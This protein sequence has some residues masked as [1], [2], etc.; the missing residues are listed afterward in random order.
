MCAG[1]E[2]PRRRRGGKRESEP[3]PESR[4]RPLSIGAPSPFARRTQAPH[5]TRARIQ[6]ARRQHLPPRP[7]RCE[8]EHQDADERERETH[9]QRR[10]FFLLSGGALPFESTRA[11]A[12]K[13]LFSPG[14]TKRLC[15]HS[16]PPRDPSSSPPSQ[17]GS[18]LARCSAMRWLSMASGGR[19]RRRRG[20]SLFPR[21]IPISRAHVPGG[22]RC[23]KP[24][25]HQGSARAWLGEPA[26][27]EA[28]GKRAPGPFP[29]PQEQRGRARGSRPPALE[30]EEEKTRRL[31]TIEIM[32]CAVTGPRF[33]VSLC[34]REREV[35]V[36]GPPGVWC[37]RHGFLLLR[38][39][40]GGGALSLSS[41]ARR[42]L[43]APRRRRRA[44][45]AVAVAL[46][47]NRALAPRK[48]L[49]LD[50]GVGARAS[51]ALSRAGDGREVGV[52]ARARGVRQSR[53]CRGGEEEGSERRNAATSRCAG[54]LVLTPRPSEASK[55]SKPR[56]PSTSGAHARA[57]ASSSSRTP[58]VRKR[59][60][61]SA[62]SSVD[63]TRVSLS[64]P[65][66]T[67][68]HPPSSPSRAVLPAAD[69]PTRALVTMADQ[70]QEFQVRA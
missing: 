28:G 14:I 54:A 18:D 67:T 23:V 60:S 32:L 50:G 8:R 7:K 31:K 44:L 68:I 17:R 37:R 4:R 30:E 64:R 35:G 25:A 27:D 33:F 55:A 53:G 70:D 40:W 34:V 39:R 11:R 12:Q 3:A 63:K 57:H 58:R 62:A 46:S 59:A 24:T 52:C 49:R 36:C 38:G 5:S 69:Q 21:P 66:R 1:K 10:R 29:R 2:R 20:V 19:P 13:N 65:P 9:R 47:G 22:K 48:T 15:I 41:L 6:R 43:V 56:S 61:V 16:A 42:A 26:C 51:A 45:V